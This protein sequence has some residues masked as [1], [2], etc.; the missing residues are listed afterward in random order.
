ML[1][2]CGGHWRAVCARQVNFGSKLPMSSNRTAPRISNGESNQRDTNFGSLIQL[3]KQQDEQGRSLYAI[4]DPASW[5]EA[6]KRLHALKASGK[7]VSLFDDTPL[8]HDD[9]VAPLV[10]VIDTADER[11]VQQLLTV[12]EEKPAVLWLAAPAPLDV[13]VAGLRTK[14][15]AELDDGTPITLR[16]FDPRVLPELDRTLDDSQRERLHDGV[17]C[18]WFEDRRNVLRTLQPAMR[19]SDKH[20]AAIRLTDIQAQALLAAAM[21]DRVMNIVAG[22]APAGWRALRRA[23]Q[24]SLVVQQIETAQS[25]GIES[26]NDFATFVSLRRA[27]GPQFEQSEDWAPLLDEVRQRRMK[28]DDAVESWEAQHA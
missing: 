23:E 21:P 27:L 3:V 7:A 6:H 4:V 5:P 20:I 24:Y 10:I 16:F 2:E 26:E 18:W 14:L 15:W 1:V 28:L 25:Y 22:E 17:A 8:A 12:A 11:L 9:E 19:V 13:L